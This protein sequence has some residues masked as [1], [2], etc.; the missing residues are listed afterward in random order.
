MHVWRL[1]GIRDGLALRECVVCGS[2][3]WIRAT[4][5]DYE[6]LDTATTGG[7]SNDDR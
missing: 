2:R 3:M 7:G 4:D 1:V 6:Q 5:A